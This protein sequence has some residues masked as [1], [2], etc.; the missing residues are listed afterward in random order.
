VK[1]RKTK[2]IGHGWTQIKTDTRN[3]G[4]KAYLTQSSQRETEVKGKKRKE[5]LT[6]ERH[7]KRKGG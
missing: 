4:Q 1:R 6:T 5:N 2:N 3:E 7:G